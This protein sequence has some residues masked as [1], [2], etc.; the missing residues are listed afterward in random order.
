MRG[1]ADAG[2]LLKGGQSAYTQGQLSSVQSQK[3][4]PDCQ[5]S[6]A[7]LIQSLDHV[8]LHPSQLAIDAKNS[9]DLG[10]IDEDGEF[11][12]A[13]HI[14]RILYRWPGSDSPVYRVSYCLPIRTPSSQHENLRTDEIAPELVPS[15]P[16]LSWRLVVAWG[17]SSTVLVVA[18]LFVVEQVIASDRPLQA[19][20]QA[21]GVDRAEWVRRVMVAFGFSC[22]QVRNRHTPPHT[23]THRHTPPHTASHRLTPPHTAPHRLTPPHTA[24]HRHTPPNTAKY[25][26][27][28]LPSVRTI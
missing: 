13:L 23:A 1:L 20:L 4:G 2:T 7:T 9:V 26:H 21:G 5:A 27:A 11:V 16:E 24:T 12:A 15:S 17:A 25:T 8:D 10:F 22:L 19:E 18:F 3:V 6:T 14:S 28:R